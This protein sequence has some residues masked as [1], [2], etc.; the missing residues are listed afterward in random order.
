MKSWK[1]ISA[2]SLAAITAAA[3]AGCA[4][5]S[6]SNGSSPTGAS[7]NL[8]TKKVTLTVQT[9]TP[10]EPLVAV[11]NAFEKKFPNIKV[12]VSAGGY[13]DVVAQ[14]PLQLAS[15]HSP[16][17]VIVNSVG[18]LAKDN[19][20]LP[21]N[22]YLKLYGWD[23]I[24]SATHLSDYSVASNGIALGGDK[25]IALPTSF[26]MVGVYYNKP[27]LTKAGITSLPT[28]T[29][30]F[31]ADLAKAKAAGVLPIQF[32]NQQGH[33]SFTIQEVAQ[34]ISGGEA[35][36]KWVYGE[37]RQVFD[38]PAN[39]AGVNALDQGNKNGY[40]PSATQ[41][42][43]TNLA[44]AVANFVGGQG[45]FFIDGNWDSGTIGTGMGE[46]VGFFP[47]PG[48]HVAGG[49]GSVAY[50]ISAKSKNP[51]QAAAFLNFFHSPEASQ[52][53]YNAGALPNTVSSLKAPAGTLKADLLQSF[54]A[55]GKDNG[56]VDAYANATASMNNTFTQQTQELIA[57]KTTVDGL[58]TAIQADWAA[59]HG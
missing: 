1:V 36:V 4:P 26:Y 37:P 28:T 17:I 39:R 54:A 34:S 20:L 53:E 46:N 40:F 52:A 44:G 41:A 47:F 35:A 2:L 10:D 38:T 25:L 48:R 9:D 13:Q 56:F 27:L 29:A 19:L 51:N 23:K 43:G 49:G 18:N 15:N 30:D 11:V 3:L 45:L 57:G 7:S 14:E 50:A 16:D 12:K 21:L 8:G 58:I 24:Y 6:A 33:G 31:E 22:P 59:T 42:N 5:G 32:G 55:I